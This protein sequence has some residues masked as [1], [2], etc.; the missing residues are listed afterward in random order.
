MRAILDSVFLFRQTPGEKNRAIFWIWNIGCMVLSAAAITFM[1]LLLAFGEYSYDI[2]FGYF[3]SSVTLLMNFLP[4]LLLLMLLY[5][6]TSRAWLS[7]CITA[8]LAVGGAIGNY[9]KLKFRDDPFLVADLPN[10]GTAANVAGGYDLTPGKRILLCA[11]GVLLGTLFLFLFV[12]G[13]LPRRARLAGTAAAVLSL[14]LAFHFTQDD[15][16]FADAYVDPGVGGWTPTQQYI[17]RGFVYPFL[18]SAVEA[19]DKKP[20][21]YNK[22]QAKAILDAYSDADIPENKR[23]NLI[24]IQLEAFAD[25]SK[26]NATGISEDVYS[27]YH[28]IEAESIHGILVTNSFAAGTQN[29]ERCFLMGLTRLANFRKNTNSYIWYLRSQGYRTTGSHPAAASNYNRQNINRWL[30]MDEYYFQEDHYASLSGGGV[31][32]Y[33]PIFL[34]E[35]LR[36]YQEDAA[37]GQPVF[38]FNVTYQGHGPYPTDYF[39]Y[40][41]NSWDVPGRSEEAWHILNNYLGS[42]RETS[43]YLWDMLEAL[44]D[45]PTPV[46]VVLYGDH[47]PWLGDS[48]SVYTELG[49]DLDTSTPEGFLNYYSTEYVIWANDAAKNLTGC[50]FSGEGETISATFLMNKVFSLLGWQGNAYMQYT[51]DVMDRLPVVGGM[52]YYLLDDQ[53]LTRDALPTELLELAKQFQRVEYYYRNNFLY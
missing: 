44:R 42:V 32:T 47:K 53:V 12:R 24:G 14:C 19:V 40:E 37:S 43:Q 18:H 38:S 36:L 22:A 23:I 1:T 27:T 34:P 29:T 20:E 10:I 33:D 9:Y 3:Q 50:F 35:L 4:V 30:G 7:Y 51:T 6:A 46:V 39:T 49:I 45:D 17:R 2:F 48:N 26:L 8:L 11:T 5:L 28:R 41:A 25:L 52:G 13:R 31:V 16:I 15:Q 21:G